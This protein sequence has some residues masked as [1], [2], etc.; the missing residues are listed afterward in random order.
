MEGGRF[1]KPAFVPPAFTCTV[2][3]CRSYLALGYFKYSAFIIPFDQ[4]WLVSGTLAGLVSLGFVLVGAWFV[5]VKWVGSRQPLFYF[6]VYNAGL[7]QAQTE[8]VAEIAKAFYANRYSWSSL[9][10]LPLEQP[11]YR[12]GLSDSPL[13][14]FQRAFFFRRP[15]ER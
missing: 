14:V 13:H 1:F 8:S 10:L 15:L 3:C 12:K 5:V 6:Y 4:V 9:S 11:L 7:T 2:R